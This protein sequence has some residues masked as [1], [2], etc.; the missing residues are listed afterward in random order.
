MMHGRL[1]AST[2]IRQVKAIVRA[3]AAA[4]AAEKAVRQVWRQLL[5]LLRQPWHTVR[6]PAVALLRALVPSV[7][8]TLRDR[9]ARQARWGWRGAVAGVKREVPQKWLQAVALRRLTHDRRGAG[10]ARPHGAATGL[11]P[12]AAYARDDRGGAEGDRRPTA[13]SRRLGA[14]NGGTTRALAEAAE[15]LSFF[16][17]LAPYRDA[18]DSPALDLTDLLFPA[19]AES[20]IDGIVRSSGWEQRL[21]AG[22]RLATPERLADLLV[23][24]LAAGKSQQEVAQD[25][26]PHVD[27]VRSS[28]RRVARTECLRVSNAAQHAAHEGLG[29]I[30][31]GYQVIATLDS[32]TRPEHAARNGTTY[33]RHPKPGQLGFDRMPHPPI[34]ADGSVAHNC[35]C[36]LV[37]VLTAP[38]ADVLQDLDALPDPVPSHELFADWFALASD[39]ERKIAVGAKRHAVLVTPR[40]PRPGWE[41]FLD[42]TATGLLDVE[43]LASE[44][45]TQRRER[46]AKVN[47]QLRHRREN[48]RSVRRTGSA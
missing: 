28:A 36:A 39:R 22:T 19:P 43:E 31:A 48:L 38:D 42:E 20:W 4:D 40:A 5:A 25:L 37:P 29:E 32:H 13:A 7:A 3:D 27:G 11:P 6:R 33:W 23:S 26:L 10:L 17:L 34:E 46:I 15:S 14:G 47:A 41:A 9:L 12:G 35:R 18:E 8:H 24:G 30:V 21:A 2:G 1:I 45:A 16:D 44:T